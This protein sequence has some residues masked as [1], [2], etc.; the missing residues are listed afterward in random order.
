MTGP[1]KSI[2]QTGAVLVGVPYLAIG[3]IG[4]FVT[5]FGGFV[6]NGNDSLLGFALN[7]FHNIIHLAVGG[8][9]VLAARLDRT[10]AEGALIGGGLVYLL[11]TFLGFDNRLQILSIDGTYAPDNFLH[12]VSGVA[13]LAI[14]I[15]SALASS[16]MARDAVQQA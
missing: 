13:V 5:G 16:R 1:Q 15:A 10:G 12:L 3:V 2:A 8:F 9:L 14:G 4:F 7:P 6:Q 11:A